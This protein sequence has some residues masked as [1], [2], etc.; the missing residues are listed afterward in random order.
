MDIGV[1][2]TYVF[3]THKENNFVYCPITTW[4]CMCG[5]LVWPNMDI[6]VICLERKTIKKTYKPIQNPVIY[7]SKATDAKSQLFQLKYHFL[8]RRRRDFGIVDTSQGKRGIQLKFKWDP[9][10]HLHNLIPLFP[11]FRQQITI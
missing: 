9:Y 3:Y 6:G 1:E 11:S 2:R 10:Y 5:D 4:K 8:L 7:V